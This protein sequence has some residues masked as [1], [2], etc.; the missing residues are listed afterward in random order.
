LKNNVT[1]VLQMEQAR[2]LVHGAWGGI[3][4]DNAQS[5]P[6]NESISSMLLS[7][8][9]DSWSDTRHSTICTFAGPSGS[10]ESL[11]VFFC[12]LQTTVYQN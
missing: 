2:A 12:C 9:V 4:G 6:Q 11:T 8:E 5:K 10:G 3:G 7:G 1:A